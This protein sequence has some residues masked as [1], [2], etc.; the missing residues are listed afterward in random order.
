[1][2]NGISAEP[3]TWWGGRT[4]RTLDHTVNCHPLFAELPPAEQDRL[5]LENTVAARVLAAVG[6]TVLG[7]PLSGVEGCPLRTAADALALLADLYHLA[8]NGDG[9]AAV[10]RGHAAEFGHVQIAD[11]PGRGEPGT[12]A[13]PLERPVA[14][15]RARGYRGLVSLEYLQTVPTR[16]SFGWLDSRE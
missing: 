14:D 2:W 3:K 4:G 12:G 11:P 9:V 5:A 8:V 16:E 13:L 1:M 6:G 10:V 15:G 7:E